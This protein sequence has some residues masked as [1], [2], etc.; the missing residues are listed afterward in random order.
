MAIEIVAPNSYPE[1]KFKVFLAGAIDMGA[2]IDWQSWVVQQFADDDIAILNPRRPEFT[3]DTLD[4]QI[5]WELQALEDATM[6]LLWFPKDA[7]APISFFEAG[8]WWHDHKLI[9]GAEYGFYRRRNLE[10]TSEWHE[11][12]LYSELDEMVW[13]IRN[14]FIRNAAG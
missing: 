7:K 10:L 4:E 13:R 8:L 5:K 6:I 11:R 2:A 9:V 3:P 12:S 1:S 14:E